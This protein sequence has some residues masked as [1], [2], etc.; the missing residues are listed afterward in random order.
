MCAYCGEPGAPGRSLFTEER[1]GKFYEL[2]ALCIDPWNGIECDAARADADLGN[3]PPGLDRRPKRT[4]RA[5]VSKEFLDHSPDR[6]RHS[7]VT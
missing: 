2:H 6:K 1:A 7:D 5:I 4:A 3:I